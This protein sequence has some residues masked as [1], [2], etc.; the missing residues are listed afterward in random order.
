MQWCGLR[1]EDIQVHS[2][3]DFGCTRYR[4][5]AL[6][7]ERELVVRCSVDAVMH[8]KGQEQLVSVKA[9]NEFDPKCALLSGAQQS[10]RTPCTGCGAVWAP[11]ANRMLF[12]SW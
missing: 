11:V 5:A 3:V 7:E 2:C 12:R 1:P 8:L 10:P 6:G 9:L 4:K